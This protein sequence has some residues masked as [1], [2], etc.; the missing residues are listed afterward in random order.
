MADFSNN[1]R[2]GDKVF[3]VEL[4]RNGLV[5]VASETKRLVKVILDGNKNAKTCD[6]T[7][8]RLVVDGKPEDVAPFDGDLPP[9]T[10]VP[11][12]T[13]PAG[14]P[15]VRLIPLTPLESLEGKLSANNARR[16]AIQK[17]YLALGAENDRLT[18]A[19]AALKA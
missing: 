19:I 8:L 6:I 13:P 10:R 4:K 16:D 14:H 15:A 7:T 1:L 17:E 5:S 18:N 11:V 12:R 9:A 3:D 2:A